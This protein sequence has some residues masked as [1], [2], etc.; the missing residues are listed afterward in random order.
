MAIISNARNAGQ[1]QNLSSLRVDIED[2]SFLSEYFVL[3]EYN[4]KF[5]AGKNT[6]LLNGSDKLASGTPIQFEALDIFGNSLYIE[7]AKTNT[8]AYKEGGAIR[9]AVYVYSDTPYG[10]GKIIL[11]SREKQTNKIVRWVGNIQINSLVQNTSKVLFYKAPTLKVNSSFVPIVI[12]RSSGYV[13]TITNSPVYT[14]AVTPRKGDDYGTFDIN[15]TPI[16]YRLT[17]LNAGLILSSSMKNSLVD[18]YVS[19]IDDVDGTVNITSSNVII[20][21][22][23]EKTVKLKNPIYYINSQNKK[24]IVNSTDTKL[25]TSFTNIRYDTRFITSSSDNQSV[26]FVEYSNIKTFCGNVYRH[27]LYRRSLSAA[28]D[29]EIVADEPILDSD[30]LI[31]ATTPNT[32]FKSLGSFPNEDHLKH[33]WYS[34]S[35]DIIMHR[36]ASHLMDS[37]Q[38]DNVGNTERYIIVKNDTNGGSKTHVYS[39]YNEAENI[40]ESGMGY[41]S[42]FMKLYPDVTYKL[43]CKSRIV[44]LNTA[45][46]AYVS[47]YI[48][49]SLYDKINSDENYDVNRGVK[50]GE[51][52]LDEQSSSLYNPNPSVFYSRFKNSFNGTM[53]I[54]TNNCSATLSDIKLTTYSEPSFSPDIFITRIPFPVSVAGEQFELKAELFD[55]NSN[56]VY[57]DLRTISTFDV[58]GS[59]VYKSIPGISSSDTTNGLTIFNMTVKTQQI[60]P[61]QGI[62][63]L[64]SSRFSFESSGSSDH[65]VTDATFHIKKG[66]ISISPQSVSTIGGKVYI[67]PSDLLDIKPTAVGTMDNVNIG[68]TTTGTG[69]F[70]TLEAVTTMTVP[71]GTQPTT[72]SQTVTSTSLAATPGTVDVVCPLK[73]PDGWLSINGKKVPYYD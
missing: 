54:Y 38:I 67:R 33:Y 4:P 71:I 73:T 63:M 11:V 5:T 15:S 50:L 3:S 58:S 46:P 57:S 10:V 61:S 59:T 56:L 41:D 8:I 69:R 6:F 32:F 31:D 7:V 26:A 72:V 17:V 48:T 44:K 39:P 27:K 37:I 28:G 1:K 19:K 24:I 66:T 18:L 2:T 43:S 40:S 9:I 35:S 65:S 21:I 68:V 16:D 22:I 20:D 64:D 55:V 53:V 45:K 60:S 25:N 13:Q 29:F 49:S 23:D 51:F 12:D 47:F 42:N 62:T 70:S 34:S 14:Y 36:S 52:Y 30:V